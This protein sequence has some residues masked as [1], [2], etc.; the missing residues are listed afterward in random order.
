MACKTCDFWNLLQKFFKDFT[1]LFQERGERREKER[2]R[3]QCVVA[4]HMPPPGGLACNP[5]MCLDWESNQQPFG[6]QAHTQSTELH[7]PGLVDL[8]MVAL[9]VGVK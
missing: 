8:L 1:Y 3:H 2:E 4:S 9:L 7:Q 5:G 6:A